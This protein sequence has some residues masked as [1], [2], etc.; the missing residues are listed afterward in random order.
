M[1]H[2]HEVKLHRNQRWRRCRNQSPQLWPGPW[3][4]F[5]WYSDWV[6]CCHVSMLS[7]YLGAERAQRIQ[8]DIRAG[9]RAGNLSD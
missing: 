8:A 4:E 1:L 3:V 6:G 9:K 5:R 7:A 2:T